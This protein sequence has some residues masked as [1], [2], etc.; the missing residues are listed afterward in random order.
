[1]AL[2]FGGV[3]FYS[4]HVHFANQAAGRIQQFNQGTY[5]GALDS[6]LYCRIFTAHTS[7]SCELCGAPSHLASACTVSA[8]PPRSCPSSSCNGSCIS[9]LLSNFLQGEVVRLRLALRI[10][11]FK[12]QVQFSFIGAPQTI[13]HRHCRHS[14]G[15]R[16]VKEVHSHSFR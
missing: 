1:M 6:E 10:Q 4:Y 15:A 12:H 13:S 7:L 9:L 11:T 16:M 5:W 14:L 3:G 8:P 2:R